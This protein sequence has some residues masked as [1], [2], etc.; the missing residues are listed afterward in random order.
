MRV[1][2]VIPARGGSKSV[3][4]KNIASV[5]GKPLLAWTILT[6]QRCSI[7]DRII[8]STD[9][10]AI[11]ETAQAWG[12]E[13]PFMRPLEL[14]RDDTPGI[15][16]ILHAVNWLARYENYWPD[17]VLVLQP[18]SPL[19][20]TEDIERAIQLAMERDAD[21][22]VSVSLAHQHPYWAKRITS[23]GHLVDFIPLDRHYVRRQ[24][25]PA[26]YVLNGAIY[27]ARRQVLVEKQSW[28]TART[29]AYI[30]PLERSLD[31]D[32]PWD[33]YLA[34]LILEDRMRA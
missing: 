27:L 18:T 26:A 5:G 8:V 28:Y 2:A 14:A 9:D 31:I 23:D 7:L 11:A 1:L 16:P 3:P 32:T 22:V 15:E 30:M 29:Y 20:T 24:D 10:I 34:D 19:R 6:A 13:V 21:S 25:L 33:L 17:Y 12:A 4:Y